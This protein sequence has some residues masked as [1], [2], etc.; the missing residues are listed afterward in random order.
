MTD[1]K[2]SESET[3][4]IEH[5]LTGDVSDPVSLMRNAGCDVATFFEFGDW[6]GADFRRSDLDIVSF[7][8]ADLRGAQ[9]VESQYETVMATLPRFPPEM[10]AEHGVESP[11]REGSI[12]KWEKF[13]AIGRKQAEPD[14][15]TGEDLV[16]KILD[17]NQNSDAEFIRQAYDFGEEMHEGQVRHSGDPYFSHPVSV[18]STLADLQLSDEVIVA[19]L[20]HDVVEDTRATSDFIEQKFGKI[21]ADMVEDVTRL[22]NL[23]H[24]HIDGRPTENF[25]KIVL[26]SVKDIRS[27]TVK[28]VDRLHN[29]R[30]ISLIRPEK[31]MAKAIE[32]LDVYAWIARQAGPVEIQEELE[33]TCYQLIDPASRS[34]IMRRCVKLQRD[35]STLIDQVGEMIVSSLNS[36]P[37][38]NFEIL[39]QRKTPYAIRRDTTSGRSLANILD[40]YQFRITASTEE[41]CRSILDVLRN[42]WTEESSSFQ[43]YFKEP[44]PNGYEAL[45]IRFNLG[46]RQSLEFQILTKDMLAYISKGI[47]VIIDDPQSEFLRKRF[48][49]TVKRF[50]SGAMLASEDRDERFEFEISQEKYVNAEP[51][52]CFTPLGEVIKMPQG[53][54]PIDFAFH[55]HTS[56]G[57]RCTGAK[58]DGMRVPL[59][60]KLEN[61]QSVEIVTAEDQ[62]P[63]EVWLDYAVSPNARRK[64]RRALR[65]S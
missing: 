64:I 17:Y 52:F 30:T 44:R 40:A 38:P 34:A 36:T 33:D 2:L 8:G 23:Q 16:Q 5:A 32:T 25:P 22:T 49:P 24:T 41:G 20:L 14:T 37:A 46:K 29:L 27:L 48:F 51:L 6:R 42:Q 10:P 54:T 13:E 39:G 26:N 7:W 60:T 1:I 18:A 50:I 55:V 47:S 21:V 59:W 65:T 31:R 62:E 43:D 3:R 4:A 45:H 63:K 35:E 57:E 61:G 19:G 28:L 12:F 15:I 56:V 58:V 11:L 9:F 53:S